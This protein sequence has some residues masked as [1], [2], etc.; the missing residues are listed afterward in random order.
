MAYLRSR[1]VNKHILLAGVDCTARDT[2]EAKITRVLS[3]F[4]H[5]IGLVLSSLT[6]CQA[7]AVELATEVSFSLFEVDLTQRY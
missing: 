5:Y 7:N 1:Y 3:M 2:G 6:R 4:P